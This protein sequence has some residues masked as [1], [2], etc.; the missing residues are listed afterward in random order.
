M[1]K[2][3]AVAGPH[4][5]RLDARESA[6]FARECE[7]IKARTYDAKPPELKALTLI[8]VNSD[9]GNGVYE[10][11]FRRYTGVG[12]AKIIADYAKDF[13]RVDVYGE[14]DSVKV[15]GIGDSYGYNVKEIRV[16]Q[17]NGKQLDVKR[18]IQARRAH[19][20]KWNQMALVSSPEIG[21]RGLLDYPG[22]TET[23][24]PADGTGGSKSWASKTVDQILRDIDLLFDAVILPTFSRESPDTL[25]LPRKDYNILTNK[26]LGDN[27]TT[28]MKYLRENKPELKRIDWLNEL[29]G[30][31]LGGTGRVM[32]GQF[33]EDHLDL[34]LPQGFEQFDAEQEGMEFTIP[35]H[36]ECAGT[37]V[38]YP[39]AFAFAD[40]L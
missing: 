31:G 29:A 15:H 24:L 28:L 4:P 25:L 22:M 37:V 33:D 34:E 11:T 26:R 1:A 21:T 2:Q 3:I 14:E 20:E 35:C 6:F 36:S 39:M 9:A 18:A 23:V 30:A 13:P 32:V 38:Y 8:P 5:Y 10:I 7:F 17:R 19:E 16:S 40:G 27:T 12:I